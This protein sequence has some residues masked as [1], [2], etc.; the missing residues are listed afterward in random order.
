MLSINGIVALIGG[1]STK[2]GSSYYALIKAAF[3]HLDGTANTEGAAPDSGAETIA[4][5]PRDMR[6]N[7]GK[8]GRGIRT[9]PRVH[10]RLEVDPVISTASTGL[11]QHHAVSCRCDRI[12]VM[13]AGH[14]PGLPVRAG[15]PLPIA[16]NTPRAWCDFNSN[17]QLEYPHPRCMYA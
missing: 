9:Q 7:R 17:S 4:P 16:A 5:G 13:G 2:P 3:S 10:V 1:N 12:P 11:N 8:F 15:P 6:I 14:S